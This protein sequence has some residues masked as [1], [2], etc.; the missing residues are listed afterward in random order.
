MRGIGLLG[1]QLLT[2]QDNGNRALSFATPAKFE[3]VK[4][5]LFFIS[6]IIPVTIGSD[7]IF[8]GKYLP[9]SAFVSQIRKS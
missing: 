5:A 6:S 4:A 2:V 1:M 7:L 9:L 3:N 8:L